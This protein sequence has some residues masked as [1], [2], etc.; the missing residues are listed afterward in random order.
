MT[1][2]IT[3]SHPTPYTEFFESYQMESPERQLFHQAVKVS[4]GDSWK[5]TVLIMEAFQSVHEILVQESDPLRQLP[6]SGTRC[7]GE[8]LQ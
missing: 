8:V 2:M 5:P 4:F 1:G 7:L 6:L 3:F